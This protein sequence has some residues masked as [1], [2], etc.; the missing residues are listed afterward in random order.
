MSIL[1]PIVAIILA[2]VT[3]RAVLSLFVGIFA[4]ALITAGWNPVT[5]VHDFFEVHLWPTLVD[6]GKMRVFAFTLL[7]GAMVGV[8]SRGGGMQGLVRKLSPYART[9]RGGQLTTWALGWAI[10]FDDYANTILLGS[11]LRPLCDRLRISREKLAYLVDSTA[12][13]IASLAI[14]STWVAVEIDYIQDGLVEIGAEESV[15]GLELFVASIPYRFYVISALLFV[16]IVAILGREFGPMRNAEEAC[17]RGEPTAGAVDVDGD[18]AS[19]D[20][21]DPEKARWYNA[22]IPIVVTLGVVIWLLYVNGTQSLLSDGVMEFGL[23]D[24]VG[25]ADSTI[26]LQY[27][28]LAGLVVAG[29][30]CRVQGLLDF[31]SILKAAGHGAKVVLPAIAILWCASTLSRQTGSKSVTGEPSTAYEYQ[32][33]RLYTGSYLANLILPSDGEAAVDSMT[34]KL[35][36]TAVFVLAAVLSFATGTSFGTMGI[37]MPMVIGLAGPLLSGSD[38]AVDPSNPILLATVASVLAGAVFGDHCSPISDTT[39]LS[40]Q[41]SGCDHMAHVVTQMPYAVVVGIF[42]VLLGTLPIGWGAPVWILVLTQVLVLIGFV[43]L[44]GQK[45]TESNQG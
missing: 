14:I 21:I 34:V 15:S 28:S 43:R 22:I 30:L 45:M 13:P 32:D 12:A 5:A 9:R 20:S 4:G 23:R 29:L 16:P 44:F 26:A 11:T 40:S 18:E 24:V 35:M 10:F 1:P 19:V 6:P 3:R 17:L 39:I 7:M 37:L 41:A 42:T 33:H 31:E 36:P 27:G 2:I 25:A 38:G 8:I